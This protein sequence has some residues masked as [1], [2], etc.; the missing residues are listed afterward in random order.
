MTYKPAPIDVSHI[1][2]SLEIRQLTE[3]LAKNA[4]EV[5]AQE[6]I[7]QGWRFGMERSDPRKEHPSLVPY[8]ELPESEKVY[9]RNTAMGT[10]KAVQAFGYRLVK[11]GEGD[12]DEP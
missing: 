4:H 11:S 8:E 3:Q 9:D 5:W 2:L 12:Q 6:R 10:L 7:A 1:K